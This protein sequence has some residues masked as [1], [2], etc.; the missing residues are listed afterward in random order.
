[1]IHALKIK[2]EYFEDYASGKKTFEVRIYDRPFEVGDYLALNEYKGEYTGR[3]ALCV[4]TYILANPDYCKE[5]YI[6]M[7]IAPCDIDRRDENLKRMCNIKGI[8]VYDREDT[9]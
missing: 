8:A 5:G 9:Q 4:I 6:I 3:C 2:P 1:M 7:S